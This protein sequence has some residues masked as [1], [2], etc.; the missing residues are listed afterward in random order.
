MR[1]QLD[2]TGIHGAHA[3]HGSDGA[4]VRQTGVGQKQ[5]AADSVG[6]TSVSR[7]VQADQ[8]SRNSRLE[9]LTAAVRAGTYSVASAKLAQALISG[10]GE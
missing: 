2:S 8:V 6:L 4:G 7:A 1:L 3:A 9:G 5:S 10:S